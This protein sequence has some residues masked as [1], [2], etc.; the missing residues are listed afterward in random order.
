MEV[1]SFLKSQFENVGL[2]LKPQTDGREGVDFLVGDKQLYVQSLDLDTK[3]SIKISK[4]E[5]GELNENLFLVLALVINQAPQVVYCIPSTQLANP[6]GRI[7]LKNE[8]IGFPSLSN[9]EIR[10]FTNSIPEL[11]KYALGNISNELKN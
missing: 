1:L 9:W 7:F 6:D 11:A 4:H 3:R 10:V 5:L 2:E 8:V